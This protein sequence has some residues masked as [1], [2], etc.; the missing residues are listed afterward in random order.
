[1]S[2]KLLPTP[3]T[4]LEEGAYCFE[5]FE[6]QLLMLQTTYGHLLKVKSI[7]KTVGDKNIYLISMG[8]GKRKIHL[9]AAHHGNEW[10]T[11]LILMKSLA[12]L[13]EMHEKN[14]SFYGMTIKRMLDTQVQYDIVP[15]LNADGVNICIKGISAVS[16]PN[17]IL[18]ANDY[19]RDFSRW[20]AN[21]RG[22]DLNRNYDAGFK[23]YQSISQ[24][25]SPSYAFYSGKNPGSEPETV[26]MIELTKQRL[27]DMVLAY[28]TQGQVIYWDYRQ[29]EVPAAKRYAEL[30]SRIST[31]AL[32]VPDPYATGCGYK[33][34]FIEAFR[35]P[36]Y[37]IEC[38][39]GENPIEVSQ[40][41]D[42]IIKTFPILLCAAFTK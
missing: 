20:K 27:Y 25:Q 12:I 22:V 26:A 7:G 37:T 16:N 15:M 19:Q 29:L 17:T 21:A 31:Y 9:N 13:C 34:W 18:K 39:L 8:K 3:I 2:F 40:L 36:G 30:F 33:D 1:M 11:S 10:I 6:R 32:D 28:H 23:E 14:M 42:I 24:S 5:T 4:Q 35:K 38:G 41:D